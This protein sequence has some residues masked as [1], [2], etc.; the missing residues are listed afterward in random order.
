MTLDA[1]RQLRA[2]GQH[3]E[4]RDLLAELAERT[5]DDAELRYEAAC[6]HDFLGREAE[7]VPHYV[8]A[9][10]AGLQGEALRGAYL[11]LGSTYRA[12]GRYA[13]AEATLRKGLATFPAA[14]EMQVF[15]AMAE[16]N[17][18]RSRAA[19]ERLLLLVA[20]TSGDEAV[21]AYRGAIE[22]YAQ[23]VDRAWPEVGDPP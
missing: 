13:E 4:A 10:A 21:R 17:L 23:D 1:A 3:A 6:V 8:A 2:A 9:I 16:H 18:G 22:F 11:G 20:E 5:P 7:A 12:L 14:R 15:L 19:V